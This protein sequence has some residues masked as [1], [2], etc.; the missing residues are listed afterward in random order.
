MSELAQQVALA[1]SL[2][3]IAAFGAKLC[4]EAEVT[5]ILA[6]SGLSVMVGY[7]LGVMK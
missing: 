5:D 7:L 3:G 1:V 4:V 6:L 2:T